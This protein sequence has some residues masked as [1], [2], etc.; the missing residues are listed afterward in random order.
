MC[1]AALFQREERSLVTLTS[2]ANQQ[3]ADA[4]SANWTDALSGKVASFRKLLVR[5]MRWPGL[6]KLFFMVRTIFTRRMEAL[7]VV[8]RCGTISG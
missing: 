3:L 7:I 8:R 1:V 4:P 5:S 2:L 6:T